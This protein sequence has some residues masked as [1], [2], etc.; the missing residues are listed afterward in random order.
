MINGES[1]KQGQKDYNEGT[2]KVPFQDF[3][4]VKK[5]VKN[6]EWNEFYSHVSAYSMLDKSKEGV[7]IG[8]LV[9]GLV[10]RDCM[11]ITDDEELRILDLARRAV[12]Q[13]PYTF[14]DRVCA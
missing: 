12:N 7:M 10:P 11:E 3:L 5:Y 6:K 4:W 14:S 9:A 13:R 8:F 2:I 1:F